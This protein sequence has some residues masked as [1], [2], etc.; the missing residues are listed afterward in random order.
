MYAKI[1]NFIDVET[2]KETFE[3]NLNKDELAKD[4]WV[5]QFPK[6]IQKF[7]AEAEESESE[8]SDESSNRVESYKT[9]YLRRVEEMTN[10]KNDFLSV[11]ML[12]EL[13]ET[14]LKEHGFNDIWSKK[15]KIENLKALG[16]LQ[17]RL[18]EIDEIKESNRQKWLELFKGVLAGNIFDSGATAVQDLLKDNLNFG[19]G[20]ALSKI[21]ERPWLIDQFDQFM[22]R[23]ENGPP[24]NCAAFF[25]D[26]SGVDVVLGVL[27]FIRELLKNNTKIILCAN[28]EPS[29][30][31]V[32]YKELI[33]VI[34]EASKICSVIRQA[35]VS[36]NLILKESGQKGCCLNFLYLHDQL[37]ESMLANHVDL[38]IIEGMG[39]SLHTNLNSKFKCESLKLAVIKNKF[40]A[41][42]LGG[43][44][45]DAICKHEVPENLI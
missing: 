43:N 23:V 4:F 10:R 1:S 14:L 20:D 9:E 33:V 3:S 19:L 31:D 26:N 27:P 6:L 11:R 30:N 22:K 45:F 13:N 28:S 2:Y 16:V 36:E 32:T 12:L 42:R 15:K 38:I 25:C 7:G 24:H 41:S 21:Q 8:K 18:N 17:Q 39:R 44:L 5:K 34:E 35:V 29:L 37:I 40:L